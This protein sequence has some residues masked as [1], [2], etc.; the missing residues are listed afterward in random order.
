VLFEDVTLLTNLLQLT[1]PDNSMFTTDGVMVSGEQLTAGDVMT[2]LQQGHDLN[3]TLRAAIRKDRPQRSQVSVSVVDVDG[4]LLG[5]FRSADA[6]VFGFDVSVQKAR[7]AAMMSR[8]DAGALLSAAEGGAFSTFVDN[9]AD[10]GLLLDGSIAF[11]DR[12]GGF[13][14]RPFLPDGIPGTMPGPFSAQSPDRFSVFN[15]G[16]QVEL[17]TTNL[18]AFLTDFAAFGDEGLA[19]QAFEDGVI[20]GG[21][22]VDVSL[23]ATNGLQIFPGSVPLYKNGVLVGAVGVSGDGIEQDDFVAFSAATGYQDFGPDIRRADEV[24]IQG[25]GGSFRLPYVKLPRAPF[26]GY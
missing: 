8:S 13:L 5:T 11:S 14:S 26:G 1:M 7:T 3:R 22:V 17:L 19:L 20:G 23:P 21:G 25:R 9:A 10:L 18:V 12:T 24:V 2:I 16:L 15:T 6:P 4:N